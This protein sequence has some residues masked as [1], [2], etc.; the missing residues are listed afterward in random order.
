[1]G[2]SVLKNNIMTPSPEEF[3]HANYDTYLPYKASGIIVDPTDVVEADEKLIDSDPRDKN[4]VKEEKESNQKLLHEQQQDELPYKASGIIVDPTD[5]IEADEILID[6]D[7]RDKNYV[8]E[9]KESNQKLLHQQQQDEKAS[10]LQH[11]QHH[12]AKVLEECTSYDHFSTIKKMGYGHLRHHRHHS[13]HNHPENY[14]RGS[15]SSP[16][17][18]CVPKTEMTGDINEPFFEEKDLLCLSS[19]YCIPISH[20]KKIEQHPRHNQQQQQHEYG[21]P[22]YMSIVVL[23]LYCFVFKKQYKLQYYLSSEGSKSRSLNIMDGD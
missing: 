6:S 2:D 11:E 10:D 13:H 8:K 17:D 7:P 22:H 23:I 12:Q 5:V 20:L 19:G 4:Y 1:M 14:T 15:C 3:P 18:Q 21:Y 16:K 9:K